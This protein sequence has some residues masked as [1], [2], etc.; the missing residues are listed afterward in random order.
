MLPCFFFPFLPNSVLE[1]G[2]WQLILCSGELQSGLHVNACACVD[3]SGL[4][5]ILSD[6]LKHDSSSL[7]SRCVL[8]SSL[9]WPLLV[10]VFQPVCCGGSF[11]LVIYIEEGVCV[12]LYGGRSQL[13]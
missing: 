13:A 7:Q 4:S 12:C 2:I 6:S 5:V 9:A 8:T 3:P 11:S 10:S 1:F